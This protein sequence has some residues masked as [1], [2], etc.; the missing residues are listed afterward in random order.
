[1]WEGDDGDEGDNEA[2]GAIGESEDR[3]TKGAN[4]LDDD[5][6]DDDVGDDAITEVGEEEVRADDKTGSITRDEGQVEANESGS[7]STSTST[8]RS[9]HLTDPLADLGPGLEGDAM[10]VGSKSS[11]IPSR[12]KYPIVVDTLALTGCETGRP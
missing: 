5:D 9:L 1:M 8:L 11:N 7:S 10:L 2:K 3:V 12:E 4:T 6:D